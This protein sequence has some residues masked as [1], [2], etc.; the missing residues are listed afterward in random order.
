VRK[1][2]YVV[3]QGFRWQWLHSSIDPP[4]AFLSRDSEELEEAT[5]SDEVGVTVAAEE[6]VGEA[7]GSSDRDNSYDAARRVRRPSNA[8]GLHGTEG[9][10]S[11]L[12]PGLWALLKRI[13][14]KQYFENLTEGCKLLISMRGMKIMTELHSQPGWAAN[15]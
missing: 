7:A 13:Y 14:F 2:D 6:E 10:D 5:D 15:P 3:P 11:V 8:F 1:S 9:R 4:A 12:K